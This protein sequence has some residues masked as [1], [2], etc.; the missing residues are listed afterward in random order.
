MS[1]IAKAIL[2]GGC[3]LVAGWLLP[4]AVNVFI[5]A[6]FVLPSLH[7]NSL[8]DELSRASIGQRSLAALAASVV[9]GLILNALQVPL[10]RILEGYLFWPQWL[11]SKSRKRQLRAKE[12]LASTF[13]SVKEVMSSAGLTDMSHFVRDYKLTFG[14]TPSQT[15]DR[16][17]HYD[18]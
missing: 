10:Y 9:V 17:S 6:I 3:S 2:G 8:A 12:L 13:L 15:R 1:D 7:G 11:A 16:A 14:E 18:S 4:T 5:F